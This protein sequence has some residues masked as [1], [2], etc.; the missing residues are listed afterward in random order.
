MV[1]V[2]IEASSPYDVIIQSGGLIHLGEVLAQY[3]S[4]CRAV[5][6]F[7][8]NAG[9]YYADTARI[10]LEKAGFIIHPY[11]IPSGEAFKNLSSFG[12]LLEFC[13]ESGLTRSDL[14]LALGGGVTGDL[15][16]FTAACFQRG[17]PFVSIPTTTL[18][19]FDASVGGKTAIDLPQGKNMAGAFHQPLLVYC[20]PDCFLSLSKERFA[21][22]AAESLKHGLIGD[23]E[24]YLMMQSDAWKNQMEECVRRNVLVKRQFVLGDEHDKG[25][26]QILNFGHT[27]GHALESL[28]HFSLSH[29][30]AVGLGL[31][32]E[33][34][35]A[36]RLGLSPVD[37]E[38]LV[39][40][41]QSC[42]LPI[43]CEFTANQIMTYALRDKKRLGNS[44][45]LITLNQIAKPVLKNLNLHEFERFLLAGENAL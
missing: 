38:P 37:P 23:P 14:F 28:S 19:A 1:S 16:G 31:L 6:A 17:I 36:K 42:G 25:K 4:P 9:V 20:D 34:R 24:L 41:L 3:H 18:A 30:E 11:R 35:A 5:L 27:I 39:S 29:G 40:L 15:V 8:T 2:R 21:D 13:A 12:Q 33:M 26:R 22:G 32:W 10:S 7:D 44:L 45:T 43:H